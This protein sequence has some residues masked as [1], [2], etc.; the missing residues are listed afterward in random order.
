MHDFK[1]ARF[2][3][4]V[5]APYGGDPATTL[6]VPLTDQPV[7]LIAGAGNSTH[8]IRANFPATGNYTFTLDER[9]Q[10]LTITAVTAPPTSP[11][12]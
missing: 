8:A 6:T 7:R 3:G 1:F 9:R 2:G 4:F 5:D 12:R 11:R 10:V